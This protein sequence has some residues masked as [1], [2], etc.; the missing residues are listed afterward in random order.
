MNYFNINQFKFFPSFEVSYYNAVDRDFLKDKHIFITD[1]DGHDVLSYDNLS[2]YI[3]FE[4]I[5]YNRTADAK[6]QRKVNFKH[7]TM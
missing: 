4:A 7:C 6:I 2:K 3:H 5:L 1:E